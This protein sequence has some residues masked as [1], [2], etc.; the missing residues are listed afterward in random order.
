MHDSQDFVM[1][2]RWL[3]VRI[4]EFEGWADGCTS[5]NAESHAE[6][7]V[8]MSDVALTSDFG[9]SYLNTWMG[10]GRLLAI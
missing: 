1:V 6:L 2:L 7:F 3:R 10:I 9:Q 5:R 4:G 8:L